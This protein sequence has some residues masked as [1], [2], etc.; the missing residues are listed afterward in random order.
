MET[1]TKQDL[2]VSRADLSRLEALIARARRGADRD[3]GYLD[4]LEACLDL[5]RSVPARSVPRDV[6]TMNTRLRLRNRE[7]DASAVYT[8]ISRKCGCGPQPDLG[9]CPSGSGTTRRLRG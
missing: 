7:T 6:V 4:H 5:A 3:T 1:A 8:L 9:P 2:Y